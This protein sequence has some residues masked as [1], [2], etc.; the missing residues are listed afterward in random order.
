MYAEEI[1]IDPFNLDV[2]LVE[3]PARFL[4][5][6]RLLAKAERRVRQA[7]EEIKVIRS[8]LVFR[9]H[10]QGE[11]VLG[12]NVKVQGQTV[13]AYYRLDKQHKRVKDELDKAMYKRDILYAAVQAF[14]QRKDALQELVRLHGQDYF[15][16]PMTTAT[17]ELA[18]RIGKEKEKKVV[19]RMRR[20]KHK[21]RGG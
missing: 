11:R 6:S 5:Y 20:T 10:S 16:K 21:K 4:K 15:S 2:E 7:E 9:A 14:R 8:E 1:T 17:G 3:Q 18:D 12:K 13:E 19:D